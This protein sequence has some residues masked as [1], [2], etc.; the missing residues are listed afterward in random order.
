MEELIF[1][2]DLFFLMGVGLMTLGFINMASGAASHN[3]YGSGLGRFFA[4]CFIVAAGWAIT[5]LDDVKIKEGESLISF[6][7]ISG[8]LKTLILVVLA[9]IVGII[10][11]I[12]VSKWGLTKRNEIREEKK[13][14]SRQQ[15]LIARQYKIL[16]GRFQ[17]VVDEFL[18]Y[19]MD[20]GTIFKA[21]LILS[22]AF[23]L[24]ADFH[25]SYAEVQKSFDTT[26]VHVATSEKLDHLD[27]QVDKLEDAWLALVSKA[28]EVKF[29]H[30]DEATGRKAEKML[31]VVLN[32]SASE[33]ERQSFAEALVRLLLSMRE[34]MSDEEIA[35]YGS[36]FDGLEEHV[37]SLSKGRELVS[38]LNVPALES[39]C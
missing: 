38:V 8:P 26:P 19:E 18:E 31:A 11:L 25:A 14:Q 37:E 5:K 39:G 35:K 3:S 29:P 20:P 16:L 21:P 12:L 15:D 33:Q 36:M 32:E 24:T 23:P 34:K 28:T 1:N 13:V 17:I 2:I 22:P 7:A 27:S 6:S 30:I 9:L 4:S 10:L